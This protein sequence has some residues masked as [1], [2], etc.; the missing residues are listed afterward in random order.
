MASVASQL[1]EEVTAH[2]Q[3]DNLEDARGICAEGTLFPN[4]LCRTKTRNQKFNSCFVNYRKTIFYISTWVLSIFHSMCSV[5]PDKTLKFWEPLPLHSLPPPLQKISLNI[6]CYNKSNVENNIVESTVKR[7]QNF[8]PQVS[9]KFQ[10]CILH[11]AGYYAGF[12]TIDNLFSRCTV[13]MYHEVC[14]NNFVL[15]TSPTIKFFQPDS[16]N[17]LVT[18]PLCLPWAVDCNL[19][20]CQLLQKRSILWLQFGVA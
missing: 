12:S 10:Y 2:A 13:G 1:I 18:R 9:A 20:T 14:Q 4:N 17:S 16:P 7:Y 15:V 6:P 11:Y 19:H 3:S 5:S 8:P